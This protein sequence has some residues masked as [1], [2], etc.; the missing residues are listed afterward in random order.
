MEA[1]EN[2]PGKNTCSFQMHGVALYTHD[3]VVAQPLWPRHELCTGRAA[4]QGF[5]ITR[6]VWLQA[7]L[8]LESRK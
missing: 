5:A 7:A 4:V 8:P 3:V 6:D 1:K 2:I